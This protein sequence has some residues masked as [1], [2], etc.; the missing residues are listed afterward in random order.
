MS[1]KARLTLREQ[2]NLAD[3][4]SVTVL[5]LRGILFEGK[6]PD[7]WPKDRKDELVDNLL[8]DLYDLSHNLTL[9]TAGLDNALEDQ[10]PDD[11]CFD[12]RHPPCETGL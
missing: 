2:Q 3:A 4:I 6:F 8:Q 7:G 12:V 9:K 1:T 5:E 10:C 11:P